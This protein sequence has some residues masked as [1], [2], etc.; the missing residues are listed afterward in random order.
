LF[1]LGTS[2]NNNPRTQLS[3]SEDVPQNQRCGNLTSYMFIVYI[4]F[5]YKFIDKLQHSS[6]EGETA[7]KYEHTITAAATIPAQSWEYNF[8]KI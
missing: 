8:Y 5:N 1:F 3:K 2:V 4:P 6:H 7:L